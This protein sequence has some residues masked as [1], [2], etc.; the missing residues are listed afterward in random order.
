M[1]LSDA[2][3]VVT[4]ARARS[5]RQ[6]TY[7]VCG[8]SA[9]HLST[10]LSA[11]FAER[12]PELALDVLSGPYGDLEGN[13]RRAST[14]AAHSAVV[15]IE[16]SD[17]DARLGPR[18]TAAFGVSVYDEILRDVAAQLGRLHDPLVEL[19]ARMPVVLCGPTL[20]WELVGHTHGT[21]ASA[22]E[23]KLEL[24]IQG[25][26]A[27]LSD[28]ESIRI[29][30]NGRLESQSPPHERRDVRSSLQT[31]FPYRLPHASALADLLVTLL[32]PSAPLKGIITDLDDTLWAGLVGEVGPEG[33]SFDQETHCQTHGL[34]QTMLQSLSEL[35]VLIGVASRNEPQVVERALDRPD[36]R[37]ARD[38]IFPVE[39]H[40]GPKSE[41]V[42][43]ILAAWNVGAESVAFVDD[44]PMELSEVEARFP[45]MTCLR[46][47][48]R[49]ATSTVALCARLRDAF[50]RPALRTEDRLRIDSVRTSEQVRRAREQG[51][52][53]SF[54]RGLEGE[55]TFERAQARTERRALEL[56]NKTNQFNLNG[57]RLSD[58][59]WG[60]LLARD[61]VFVTKVSYRDRLGPLGTISVVVGQRTAN[62]LHV[63]HWVL[64]CR[65]FARRIEH[66][67]LAK[68]L[69]ESDGALLSL[70]YRAT[71][72]NHVLR[73]LLAE[74]RLSPDGDGPIL[75]PSTLSPVLG[76]HLVHRTTEPSS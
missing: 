65:A 27:Q 53:D 25:F 54:L 33:V 3:R 69:S 71:D 45:D 60:V 35:G 9:L 20:R 57:E 10:F 1:K 66:H 2:L 70:R 29:Q 44:S 36:L 50:G 11:H 8:G 41:L 18:A 13:L 59:E 34:Y 5:P 32:S 17:L 52:L 37:I 74:L 19:A 49:D 72:K 38:R 67:V 47:D 28:H 62:A 43:A 51:D 14:S 63:L 4:E 23:L 58:A 64:S 7:L 73:E 39:A 24:L 46:F 55:L 6:S 40:W 31:G 30:H 16:L 15:V 61:D 21:Q 68:L 76:K 22:F 26:L 56:I 48:G 42:A 75:I 12:R